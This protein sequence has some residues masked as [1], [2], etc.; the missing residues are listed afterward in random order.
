MKFPE[1]KVEGSRGKPGRTSATRARSALGRRSN[2]TLVTQVV[3]A[4]RH[5]QVILCGRITGT[6]PTADSADRLDLF[7]RTAEQ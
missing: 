7:H 6:P 5:F 1:D 3:H 4:L 2:A